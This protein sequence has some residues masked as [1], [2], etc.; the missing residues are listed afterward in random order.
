MIK[1]RNWA[2]KQGRRE[3]ERERE[4]DLLE[5]TFWTKDKGSTFPFSFKCLEK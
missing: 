2:S 5:K 1:K 4:R 3:R